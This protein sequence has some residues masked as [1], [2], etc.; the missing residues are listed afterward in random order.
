MNHLIRDFPA[1]D[2]LKLPRAPHVVDM[3]LR[4]IRG[5]TSRNQPHIKS[6][7]TA[8][9][10][11]PILLQG[12]QELDHGAL[13]SNEEAK[14]KIEE[15]MLKVAQDSLRTEDFVIVMQHM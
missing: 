3:F 5:V 4:A 15:M 10:E 12:L 2:I 1:Q 9:D 6:W 7:Y 11:I 13:Q 14:I 8:R